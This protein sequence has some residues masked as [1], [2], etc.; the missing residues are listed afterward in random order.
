MAEKLHRSFFSAVSAIAL[1]AQSLVFL[2]KQQ[3]GPLFRQAELC[4]FF[5]GIE[6]LGW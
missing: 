3:F 5:V 4:W 1:G 2:V 6:R